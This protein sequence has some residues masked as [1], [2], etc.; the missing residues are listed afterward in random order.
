M[1]AFGFR[2]N[3]EVELNTFFVGKRRHELTTLECDVEFRFRG[4]S[5]GNNRIII[6]EFRLNPKYSAIT[7]S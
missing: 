3:V 5:G 6:F 4:F 7:V 2:V 1:L